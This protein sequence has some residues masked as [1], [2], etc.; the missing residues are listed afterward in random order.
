MFCSD[1]PSP[2]TPLG[3][4]WVD[5]G[6]GVLGHSVKWT[7]KSSLLTTEHNYVSNQYI[8]YEQQVVW[9]KHPAF[10]PT[11]C[12]WSLHYNWSTS[13]HL[14]TWILSNRSN[15]LTS[16]DLGNKILVSFLLFLKSLHQ[17]VQSSWT[18]ASQR[19]QEL[20]HPLLV[21]PLGCA[22][23]MYVWGQ[24]MC[25]LLQH[26]ILVMLASSPTFST[27]HKNKPPC[28]SHM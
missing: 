7:E 1:L 14:A 23:C 21:G 22:S 5:S 18:F 2:N 10:S 19:Y 15:A 25:V 12:F 28:A 6:V 8:L 11:F 3:G 4:G 20:I 27:L 17:G 9:P 13:S 24:V 26:A 16:S